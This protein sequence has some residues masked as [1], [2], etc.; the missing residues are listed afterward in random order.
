MRTPG[1]E[2]ELAAGFL[3]TEGL[4]DDADMIEAFTIGDEV[5]LRDERVV[6]CS[7]QVDGDR[8]VGTAVGWR[9]RRS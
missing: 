7:G 4:I 9:R 2:Q 1:H 5:P 3:R 8:V 6:E